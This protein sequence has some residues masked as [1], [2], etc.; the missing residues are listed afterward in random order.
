MPSEYRLSAEWNE[1]GD[2]V[3]NQRGYWFALVACRVQCDLVKN[4]AKLNIYKCARGLQMVIYGTSAY[5][6]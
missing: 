6:R 1:N 2:Q 4:E 5:M 3:I